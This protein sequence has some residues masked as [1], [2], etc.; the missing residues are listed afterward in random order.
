MT[1]A[2]RGRVAIGAMA[3]V[4]ASIAVAG[5]EGCGDEGG[6]DAPGGDAP[7]LLLP[8][9]EP[10]VMGAAGDEA[11][12]PPPC[13]HRDDPLSV[14]LRRESRIASEPRTTGRVLVAEGASHVV[15]E[16][17]PAHP[18]LALK[19]WSADAAGLMTMQHG[20]GEVTAMPWG[21]GERPRIA[22]AGE[23]RWLALLE[24]DRP[25]GRRELH[26]WRDGDGTRIGEAEALSPASLRCRRGW[27]AILT[28]PVDAT[29]TPT[30]TS[31]ASLWLGP[32]TEPIHGWRRVELEAD[33]A[34]PFEV[35]GLSVTE[36]GVVA[37]ATLVD[38]LRA[39]VFAVDEKGARPVA[40]P[41]APHG[42]VATA[43]ATEP[44]VVA[45][46]GPTGPRRC[47][48]SG[49]G[50][51]V[52]VGDGEAIQL[53][54]ALPAERGDAHAIDG[55]MLVTWLAPARCDGPRR[56]LHAAILDE[57]GRPA[58]PVTV[59]GEAESY[60]VA[61]RGS[62]VDLWLRRP[63]GLTGPGDMGTVLYLRARCPLSPSGGEAGTAPPP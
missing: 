2:R 49:G 41:L 5:C 45:F 43:V 37:H 28:A 7:A 22:H 14:V 1:R 55:G 15:G 18:A 30:A 33:A 21:S 6:G 42:L 17:K 36:K 23:R 34:K 58:A 56:V 47:D 3:A 44:V 59:V 27:C 25:E 60:A 19:R 38:D 53:R 63:G 26:L 50:V 29:G 16:R 46:A 9:P 52:T 8:A 4:G 40:S 51:N 35:S 11:A 31:G 61:A 57:R 32:A 48:A 10:W 62:D 24:V 39:H 20:P 12:L 54:S 13:R